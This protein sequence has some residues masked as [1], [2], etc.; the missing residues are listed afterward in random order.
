MN[1]WYKGKMKE[2][3]SDWNTQTDK[4][5]TIEAGRRMASYEHYEELLK[6]LESKT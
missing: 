2:A 3:L 6:S 5:N 1:D 4:G